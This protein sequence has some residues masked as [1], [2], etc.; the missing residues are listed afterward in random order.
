MTDVTRSTVF[1]DVTIILNKNVTAV[2]KNINRS[3]IKKPTL[4]VDPLRSSL[5]RAH[6]RATSSASK[7]I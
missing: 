2:V 5:L 3:K 7:S 4:I 6:V 1:L